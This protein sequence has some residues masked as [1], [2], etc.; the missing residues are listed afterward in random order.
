MSD[1]SSDVC[2]SDLEQSCAVA[3]LA[4]YRGELTTVSDLRDKLDGIIPIDSEF[5]QIFATASSSKSALARYY[6]RS[7]AQAR[8]NDPEPYFEPN[9][10]P[11]SI[12]LEHVLPQSS[13]ER[14]VGKECVTALRPR[15]AP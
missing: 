1:W 5:E 15:W 10:D 13:E 6:L 8:D 9:E 3:A 14:R 12:T 11:A 2:S 4:S 7:L